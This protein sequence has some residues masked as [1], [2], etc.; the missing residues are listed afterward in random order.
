MLGASCS[1]SKSPSNPRKTNADRLINVDKVPDFVPNDDIGRRLWDSAKQVYT[2]RQFRPAWLAQDI[3]D[4]NTDAALR[5]LE[6]ASSEGLRPEDFGVA[7]LRRLRD[8]VTASAEPEVQSEFDTRLTYALVHY[9]SELCF[10]RIAPSTVNPD[11]PEAETKCDLSRI[12]N[13]ALESNTVES[14]ATQLSPKLPEYQRLKSSLARYRE[15]A[16]HG[17]WQPL[18][19]GRN[20]LAGNLELLGDLSLE[21]DA[22]T[23]SPKALTEAVRH[24]QERHGLEADGRLG[25]KTIEALNVPVSQRIEQIEINMDRMRW[26]ASRLESRHIRVNIPGFQLSVYDGDHSPLQMRA[27]VG[28]MENPTPILYGDLEYLVFSPYW[29]IPLSIATKEVLPQ[30]QKNPAYLKR[31]NMEVVRVKKEKVE[32]IDPSKIDWNKESDLSGYQLRQKPGPT[33]ALG[34]VKFIFPN[35]YNVYLHDTPSGNLFDRLTR[36]LSHGCVRVEHPADLALYLL[37]DQPEWT[38][39]LIEEAMHAE[40]EKRV[41][42]KTHVPIYLIYWTA[43]T[44]KEGNLQ[45]REDVY[46]YDHEHRELTA[47]KNALPAAHAPNVDVNK[48]GARIVTDSPSLHRQRGLSK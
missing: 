12:V 29:N 2:L 46:G 19:S 25:K 9:V 28:S 35:P 22:A 33:N 6:N 13:D 26:I 39:E 1:H 34:L 8:S 30:V 20:E 17:G 15:I 7:D 41:P 14:L 44:D 18:S 48:V 10:G 21:A 4:S 32:V 40:K 3:G 5:V 11:W 42:L 43:W 38:A 31:E 27:I 37:Q 24:F 36:T 47:P 16:E 23:P 45:F